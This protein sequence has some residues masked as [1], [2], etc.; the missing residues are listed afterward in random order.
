[1]SEKESD[2][3]SV[4]ERNYLYKIYVYKEVMKHMVTAHI[5]PELKEYGFNRDFMLYLLEEITV[6][7]FN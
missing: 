7:Q 1:M 6:D 3:I 4:A 2:D 5:K